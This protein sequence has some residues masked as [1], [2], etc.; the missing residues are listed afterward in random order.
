MPLPAASN[1]AQAKL[2]NTR[3]G[4]SRRQGQSLAWR[5]VPVGHRFP[6]SRRSRPP[7]AQ[8]LLVRTGLADDRVAVGPGHRLY[9]AARWALERQDYW[10]DEQH[11][12]FW[13]PALV[14]WPRADPSRPAEGVAA[15]TCLIGEPQGAPG[16]DEGSSGVESAPGDRHVI[17]TSHRDGL[18][19]RR[20]P[21]TYRDHQRPLPRVYEDGEP[22]PANTY[23]N[24]QIV[25]PPGGYGTPLTVER[26]IRPAA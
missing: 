2:R 13:G 10:S 17:E 1:F 21:G 26:E 12:A 19:F 20:L 8:R 15:T 18:R 6:E 25:L 16:A 14:W 11:A 4:R 7:K 9:R 22:E 5:L 24:S 3:K 23:F